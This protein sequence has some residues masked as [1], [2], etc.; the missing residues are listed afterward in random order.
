M[1]FED[2]RSQL[3]NAAEDI[4]SDHKDLEKIITDFFVGRGLPYF[5]LD[6]MFIVRSSMH[7]EEPGDA[8]FNNISR[9]SYPPDSIKGSIKLQRAN[10]PGQQVF[11]CTYPSETTNSSASIT[12]I[13]ETAWEHITDY[14]RERIMPL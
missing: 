14:S 13:V 3:L 11:Y 4:H 6:N 7:S 2:F 12:C 9:C 1:F 5:P 8:V 10:Y